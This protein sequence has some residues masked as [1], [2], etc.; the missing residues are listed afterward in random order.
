MSIATVRAQVRAEYAAWLAFAAC[1]IAVFMQMIDVTIVNT[2]LP[3]LTADLGASRSAQLLVVSGY[4]LAFACTLLT[5][6][7]IGALVGRRT[8]FLASVAAFTAASLWCGIAGGATELVLARVMQG[9]A[10]AGMAAQTI[11]VLTAGFPRERHPL[12]FALYGGVAGFAG[13]LGP[14]VG[15]VLLTLDLGGWG[16][17]SVFLI[18]LPIGVFAFALA[19]RFLHVGRSGGSRKL[20]LGGAVLSAAGLFALIYA[21][22]EIQQHGLRFGLIAL[23]GAGLAV[24]AVFVVHQRRRTDPLIRLELFT[25]RRFRLGSVLVGAFFGLFTAFVFAASVTMQDVLGYTPL[26]TGL[27]MT[28]FALGAGTGA[29]A[30]LILV[31]RWGIRAL[32]AGMALY[33]GCL[34]VGAIYLYLTSG[35]MSAL[36]TAGPVFLSG[37]GVG[38]FGIQL[39]PIMLSGLTADHMAE[40][41]GVLPTV[42]QIGNAVGLTVL[43]TLF[44]RSHTLTG[45]ITMMAAVAAVALVIALATL[46]LPEPQAP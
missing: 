26:V 37:V 43:T 3:E 11:A 1:L 12:V 27:V 30:S 32:A 15:G 7:R 25:D 18:N 17:R 19:W 21:L 5:A 34:A 20:D 8:M 36:L 14:I 10:G 46:A 4:S 6:A 45:S 16:W 33:G 24:S 31:R 2:A 42:E 22:A 13:M 40:A 38:V 35:A 44:F 41:S 39:Q 29:L 23:L 9:A 28:L